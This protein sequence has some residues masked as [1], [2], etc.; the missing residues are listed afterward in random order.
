MTKVDHIYCDSCVFLAYFQAEAGRIQTLE[1]LFNEVQN[2]PNRKL[3]TSVISITEVT[4]LAEEKAQQRLNVNLDNDLDEFWADSTLLD[5][6]EFHEPMARNARVLIRQAISLG[7]SLKP[8]DAIHLASAKY[9]GVSEFFTY[10][11]KLFKYSASI[12]YDILEPYVNQPRLPNI[13]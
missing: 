8:A 2:D 10:D 11:S 13:D 7:Y 1:Q 5:F 12:G 9:A 3:V 4:H 6:I